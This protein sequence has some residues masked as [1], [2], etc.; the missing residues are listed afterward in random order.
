MAN[1]N[2]NMYHHF[3][4]MINFLSYVNIDQ[5]EDNHNQKRKRK[6]GE[7]SKT[8]EG[9][10]KVKELLKKMGIS[11]PSKTNNQHRKL[12]TVYEALS[13]RDEYTM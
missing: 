6:N 1:Y 12:S 5:Y 3:L 4:F 13:Q 7:R 8:P 11:S 2:T 9:N 10:M